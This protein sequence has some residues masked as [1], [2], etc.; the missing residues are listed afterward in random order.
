MVDDCQARITMIKMIKQENGDYYVAHEPE[1][2]AGLDEEARRW[3]AILSPRYSAVFAE[4]VLQETRD[5]LE[6][7]I[8]EIPYIGGEENH[9]TG[10]LVGSARC[11]AFY[12]AMKARGKSAEEMGK[13]MYDAIRAHPEDFM[14]LRKIPPAQRLSRSELM[15]R[16]RERAER[17]Q[18]RRYAWD[19]VYEFVEGD[20][21]EF[22][23]GYNF[24]ECATE[25][26]YRAQGAQELLPFYCFLDFPKCELGGLGLSR[27]TT[28]AEGGEKC[29][30][31][32][33]EGATSAEQGWPPPFLT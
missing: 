15:R 26:F 5:Q 9:L 32:F 14:S 12:R 27:T 29:D 4:A 19:W 17:S 22:D 6:T 21:V 16:R 23:Y 20:G 8:P 24:F 31:Q 28:L 11:L 3:R 18:E 1:I 13:V 2:L 7:L 25:K 33:K 30:F 10:S